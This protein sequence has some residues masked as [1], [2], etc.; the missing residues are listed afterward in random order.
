[1]KMKAVVQDRYGPPEVLRIAVVDRPVPGR[2]QVLVRVRA[3]TVNRTDCHRRGADQA[4]WRLFAGLRRPRI[5]IP[6]SEFAGEIEAVGEAVTGFAMGDEVF[7]FN[8]WTLGAHAEFVRAQ[9]D[10]LI[11]HL[12]AGMTFEQ[13][14]AVPDGALNALGCLRKIGVGPGQFVLVYGATGSIGTA[15]V[16][17]A[18]HF[19]AHVTAVAAKNVELVRSLGADEV[20]DLNREDFTKDSRKYDVVYD[21]VGKLPFGRARGSLRRGGVYLTTDKWRNLFV[22]PWYARIVGRRGKLGIPPR[23]TT[24]DVLLL[25][26]LIET[27]R[28]R[29]VIDRTYPL[30]H[31]VEAAHFVETGQKTGNVVLTVASDP[32][33]A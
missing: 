31:V 21:A 15:A 18:A 16:Q 24:N 29:A 8:Q 6:G 13:A 26:E 22:T 14:A 30:E 2:N 17:L 3:A 33:S 25:K 27:G 32:A 23:Y 4:V 11:A 9:A 10:G 12:P 5:R 7:G 28:Y 1:M 20:I 19:G